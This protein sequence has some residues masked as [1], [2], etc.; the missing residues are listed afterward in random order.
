[1]QEQDVRVG[2]RL[3]P[4]LSV[5]DHNWANEGIQEPSEYGNSASASIQLSQGFQNQSCLGLMQVAGWV[6]N[7]SCLKQDLAVQAFIF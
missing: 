6:D 4:L 7:Y 2:P 1:M 5:S 3:L